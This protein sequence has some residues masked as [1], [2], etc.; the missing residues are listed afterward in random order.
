MSTPPIKHPGIAYSLR[1][2]PAASDLVRA[3]CGYRGD[4]ARLVILACT[5]VDLMEIDVVHIPVGLAS[6][7]TASLEATSVVLPDVLHR[8]LK[9]TASLRGCSMNALINSA[10]VEAFRT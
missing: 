10:I 8:S 9:S 3:R 5:S 6:L 2:M 1:L 4:L 7:G